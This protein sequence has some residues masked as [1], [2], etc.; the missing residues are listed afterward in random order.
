MTL[1]S[2]DVENEHIASFLLINTF[3]FLLVLSLHGVPRSYELKSPRSIMDPMFK[4]YWM[5]YIVLV[6]C[7]SGS[8][9]TRGL[10]CCPL[11]VDQ[12]TQ[13][14]LVRSLAHSQLVIVQY[15][16][17]GRSGNWVTHHAS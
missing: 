4:F 16:L 7:Q 13:M 3:V 5:V 6:L 10:R 2:N 8:G 14:V 1:S 17:K 11:D 12:N 15:T 9:Y